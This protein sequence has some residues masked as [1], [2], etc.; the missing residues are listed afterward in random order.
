MAALARELAKRHEV[1]VLTSRAANLPSHSIDG[2]VN[3]IRVPVFFRKDL[4]T[5]NFPSMMAYLPTAAWRGLLLRP[6][7]HFDVINTHFVVPTGPVGAFLSFVG[8]IPNVLS[9]HGG[10][11][12]DPSK[13]MSPHRHAWLR[14]PIARML[15]KAT[16]VVG[17]SKDTNRRVSEIYG[18]HRDTGLIPLGIDRPRAPSGASRQQFGIP[19]DAFVM[20]TI[21]RQ[22]P[23]KDTPQ[24]VRAMAKSGIANAHLLVVGDGPEIP[25]IRRVAGELGV[26]ERV[27][28]LG[29]VSEEDKYRALQVS[30]IFASTSQHEGFGL[31]FLE[32][33]AFG[34]P[35]VCYDRGGQVDFLTTNVTGHVV[36]LNDTDA[37]T[38]ALIQLHASESLRATIRATNLQL[39][40][41]FFIER[42]AE[43]Y[44]A[45]FE[46]VMRRPVT[47][48]PQR[49][50][51]S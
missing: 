21:G 15:R 26:A 4:A 20:V 12:Y 51:R 5:A 19:E 43:R 22:V 7:T 10:D 48:V 36:K 46:S 37:F 44:E 39:V 35:V 30:D 32:A 45:V 2:G 8:G 17:Q 49:E 13:S 18:V 47:G 31:V 6:G 29:M 50:Q 34:L 11:L 9:I 14:A 41:N 38:Q 27:H 42:C 23:R 3:V 24:L 1:T 28:P 33:M 16:A 40:E 25:E